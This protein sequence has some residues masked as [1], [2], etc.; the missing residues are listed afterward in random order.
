MADT[1][2]FELQDQQCVVLAFRA[3]PVY[4]C[5][6]PRHH[7][8]DLVLLAEEIPGGLYAMASQIA[9]S[10]TSSLFDIPE[11]WTVRPTVG[12]ARTHP[13]HASQAS[14]FD[15]LARFHDRGRENFGLRIPVHRPRFP[16]GRVH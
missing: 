2:A 4:E 15:G 14:G 12:F 8:Y 6:A 1:A 10:A 13:D 5:G 9:E 7:L 16:G 11:M 3:I